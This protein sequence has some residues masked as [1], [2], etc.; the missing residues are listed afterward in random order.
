MDSAVKTVEVVPTA[1]A[2]MKAAEE[3]VA[4]LAVVGKAEAELMEVHMGEAV[5][6]AVVHRSNPRLASGRQ[7]MRPSDT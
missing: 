2:A 7:E 1:D 6:Q 4:T 3:M 5:R